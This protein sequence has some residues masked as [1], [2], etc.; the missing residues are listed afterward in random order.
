LQITAPVPSGADG[1]PLP[2]CGENVVGVILSEISPLRPD[3]AARDLNF[4]L[5]LP[6]FGAFSKPPAPAI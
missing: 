2:D 4:A 1:G 5:R 6:W 3:S